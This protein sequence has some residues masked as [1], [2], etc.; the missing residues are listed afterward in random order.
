V[1]RL[2]AP[3]DVFRGP[4][5]VL[6]RGLGWRV[7]AVHRWIAWFYWMQII[8]TRCGLESVRNFLIDRHFGGSCGGA[9]PTRFADSGARGT[10]SVDYY[11]LPKLFH[12]QN[13]VVIRPSDVL[14]DVG[15]GKG[16]VINWW[17]GRGLRNKMIGIEL[18]ER[19]AAP[20]AERLRKYSNV[21]I[22][23]GNAL[24][25][26]PPDG[27]LFFLFNPFTAPVVEA[28]K[29]RVIEVCGEDGDVTIVYSFCVH[30]DIFRNDPRWVVEPART[31]TFWPA[32]VVRRARPLRTPPVSA[33]VQSAGEHKT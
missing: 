12:E 24:E 3:F 7:R 11:Q 26:I 15:C 19:F 25:H 9:Y 28:F 23:C 30:A 1:T 16:R 32:V 4:L 31:K 20:T 22:V 33:R 17:L 27:T 5:Q 21:S 10:S 14:L 29:D 6:R 13:G 8:K 2:A 18:D